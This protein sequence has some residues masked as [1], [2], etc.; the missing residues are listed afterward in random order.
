MRII[1]ELFE[2]KLP[3]WDLIAANH[4]CVCNLDKDSWALDD[5]VKENC[6]Y[7]GLK[8]GDAPTSV[9]DLASGNGKRTYTLLNSGMFIFTPYEEQWEAMLHFLYSNPLIKT[10]L[11][12][13]AKK[14][15]GVE[16]HFYSTPWSGSG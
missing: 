4:A 15:W 14:P 3:R 2:Y 1:D 9:P 11:R 5:W 13:L 8:P 12:L 16:P 7:T 6:A 10:F